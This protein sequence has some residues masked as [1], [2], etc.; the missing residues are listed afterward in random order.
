MIM[1]I[2]V[3][4]ASLA[5]L[6]VQ[7]TLADDGHGH[8]PAPVAATG[9]ALPRFAASSERFELV[10]VIDGKQ[11]TLYLDR[12]DD[13][14]PIKGAK[15]ELELGGAQVALKE[16]TDGE[17]EATLA[18]ELKPGLTPLTATVVAGNDTDLL[19]ADIEVHADAHAARAQVR[20]G[21]EY[22]GWA[23][24]AVAVMAALA[25][26]GRRVVPGRRAGGAA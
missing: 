21:K 3:G 9:P 22:L 25:W 11:L 20:S 12:F 4:L 6:P 26:L 5:A 19:A 14:S 10:G 17:F 13:N 8:G 15:V 1:R 2:L 24:G 16:H 18:Q 23:A 7:P